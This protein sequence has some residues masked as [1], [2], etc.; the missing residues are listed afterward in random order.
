MFRQYMQTCLGNTC[1]HVLENMLPCL[2]DTCRHVSAIYA[3][4]F[5]KYMQTCF[6]KNILLCFQNTY[7][8]V[9][10]K[11]TGMFRQYILL[12]FEKHTP[13]FRLYILVCFWKTYSNV[14]KIHTGMFLENILLY[15]PPPIIPARSAPLSWHNPTDA[16]PLS[17]SKRRKPDRAAGLFP[18]IIYPCP[19]AA[20][21]GGCRKGALW[22]LLFL[23]RSSLSPCDPVIRWA[24]STRPG[25]SVMPRPFIRASGCWRIWACMSSLSALK[26]NDLGRHLAWFWIVESAYYWSSVT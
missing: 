3:P 4:M 6:F 24:L 2:G 18:L 1:H 25:R 10:I 5:W 21:A 26:S 9:S 17:P 12:C 16:L 15:F 8:Y 13:M 23:S 14:L 22:P 19:A 7:C 11:H 20:E